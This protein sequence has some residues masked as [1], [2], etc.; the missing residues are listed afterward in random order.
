MRRLLL[1]LSISSIC[2][3]PYAAAQCIEFASASANAKLRINISNL[4]TPMIVSGSAPAITLSTYELANVSG[5]SATVIQGSTSYALTTLQ[6]RCAG[7][8]HREGPPQRVPA[9]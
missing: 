3:L 4:P 6:H 8:S 2:T 5:N 7:L 1:F 9:Q